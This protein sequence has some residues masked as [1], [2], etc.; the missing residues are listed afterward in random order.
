MPH[1]M[2]ESKTGA[3][4]L[5][6]ERRLKLG[7]KITPG[8]GLLSFRNALKMTEVRCL[9][10]KRNRVKMGSQSQRRLGTL[11]LC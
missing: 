7:P 6:F 9:Q 8:A 1:S 3:L 10:M 5:G 11:A 4:R 2:V